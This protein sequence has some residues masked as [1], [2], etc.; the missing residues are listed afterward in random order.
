MAVPGAPGAPGAHVN[1]RGPLTLNLLSIPNSGVAGSNIRLGEQNEGME[2]NRKANRCLIKAY[3]DIYEKD[4]NT[5]AQDVSWERGMFN[6]V[7]WFYICILFIFIG[8]IILYSLS[9]ATTDI[10]TINT[11]S[12]VMMILSVI[13]IFGI[14]IKVSPFRNQSYCDIFSGLK[15]W[16]LFVVIGAC[17][18]VGMGLA[19]NAINKGQYS[20]SWTNF[21]RRLT[22]IVSV[23]IMGM[24]IAYPIYAY[25]LG[26]GFFGELFA[27]QYASNSIIIILASLISLSISGLWYTTF[28]QDMVR[29]TSYQAFVGGFAAL[30]GFGLLLGIWRAIRF[31]IKGGFLKMNACPD[32]KV[33]TASTTITASILGPVTHAPAF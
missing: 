21:Y 33:D 13:A 20:N 23:F 6:S 14:A 3:A 25:N 26:A 2:L 31:A 10:G 1:S 9:I 11:L 16:A 5:A 30:G 4:F 19:F 17:V 8:L 32:I 15:I 12:T 28:K 24:I 7:S 18:G 22:I 29:N 27:H